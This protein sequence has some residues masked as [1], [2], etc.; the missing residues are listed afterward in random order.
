MNARIEPSRIGHAI[1]QALG[2]IVAG[3]VGFLEYEAQEAKERQ[4]A[5]GGDRK[6]VSAS[7]RQPIAPNEHGKASEKSA[8]A[9]GASARNALRVASV[10]GN[11][12][13]RVS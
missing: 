12:L 8:A 3:V 7:L 11:R 5:S 10:P 4:Q 1:G 13:S 2:L 9:T 6:S